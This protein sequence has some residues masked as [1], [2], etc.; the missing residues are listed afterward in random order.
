MPNRPQKYSGIL[1]KPIDLSEAP[2]GPDL[3]AFVRGEILKKIPALLDH[4][5]IDDAL[6]LENKWCQVAI[7]LALAHVPGFQIKMSKQR[8]A[9][10]KWTLDECRALINAIGAEK[11]NKG[12]KVAISKAM[13]PQWKWSRSTASIQ[14]RYHEAVLQIKRDEFVRNHPEGVLGALMDWDVMPGNKSSR[15]RTTKKPG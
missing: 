11:T 4:Y 14:T 7:K 5:G 13:K 3:E 15:K 1:A 10:R 2:Y 8:G 12:L 9:K 6:P